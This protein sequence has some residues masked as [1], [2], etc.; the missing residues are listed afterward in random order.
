MNYLTTGLDISGF[1]FWD[2]CDN[3]F[4][5]DE[6][7]VCQTTNLTCSTECIVS[8][9]WFT[10]IYN[11]PGGSDSLCWWS[12]FLFRDNCH[13]I[14]SSVQSHQL[15]AGSWPVLWGCTA[16]WTRGNVF[17]LFPFHH[18]SEMQN[19]LFSH[20]RWQNVASYKWTLLRD[21]SF[22]NVNC[23]LV[24][25]HVG[26]TEKIIIVPSRTTKWVL[27]SKSWIVSHARPGPR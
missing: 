18:L 19:F 2:F 20:K 16:L 15:L 17:P 5:N 22:R 24:K 1:C 6:E 21:R 11:W 27:T 26:F 3:T 10:N 12:V 9:W 23:V 7:T 25:Y 14:C 8:V 13:N 4:R